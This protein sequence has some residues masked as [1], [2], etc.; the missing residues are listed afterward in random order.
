MI[1]IIFHQGSEIIFVRVDNHNV[2]FAT[3]Q[4]PN[5]FGSIDG[6]R[7]DHEGTIKQFPDLKDHENWREEA[8]FRFKEHLKEFEKEEEVAE[9]VIK[10][11]KSKGFVPQQKLKHGHRPQKIS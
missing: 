1:D 10:E 9:Y 2:S 11:L 6:L 8:I 7:L 5:K 4:F 3:S